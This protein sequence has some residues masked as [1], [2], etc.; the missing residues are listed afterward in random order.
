MKT[1]FIALLTA[2]AVNASAQPHFSMGAGANA[3]LGREGGAAVQLNAGYSFNQWLIEYDQR[4][5]PDRSNPA[6]MG[7]RA[8]WHVVNTELHRTVLL[9]G[10]SYGYFREYDPQNGFY[11]GA[12]LSYQYMPPNVAVPAGI[13]AEVYYINNN[14]F[15]TFKFTV[16]IN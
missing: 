1:L 11:P 10:C 6:Y 12:G 2:L 7:I 3:G 14:V 15:T 9:A 5:V 8:G 13:G 4:F 16:W